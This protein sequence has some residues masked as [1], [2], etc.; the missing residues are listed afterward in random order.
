MVNMLQ[1]IFRNELLQLYLKY[2]FAP[3]CSSCGRISSERGV[4]GPASLGWC[5]DRGWPLRAWALQRL[6]SALP[7]RPPVLP[8]ASQPPWRHS[9]QRCFMRGE[10]IE[11]LVF[12]LPYQLPI[13]FWC[14]IKYMLTCSI[15]FCTT[16]G[17]QDN[18]VITASFTSI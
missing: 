18:L 16:S 15:T 12:V 17:E 13:N 5:P 14:I 9:W 3:P 4:T 11:P 6:L 2:V 8:E 10:K 7:G 1:I